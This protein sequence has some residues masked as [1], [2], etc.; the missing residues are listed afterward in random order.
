MFHAPGDSGPPMNPPCA[1]R[2]FL[3][4]L[5][6]DARLLIGGVAA[7]WITTAIGGVLL[8][9][10]A[11]PVSP[12]WQGPRVE[13]AP[14]QR[15]A[16]LL[17]ASGSWTSDE[18]AAD[19]LWE[20][21]L[22][23][24]T[25]LHAPERSLVLIERLLRVHPRSTHTVD[26]MAWRATL[27]A[28][29]HAPEAGSAYEAVARQAPDHADAGRWWLAAADHYAAHQQ[30]LPAIAAYQTATAHPPQ[31][32][33]AWLALGRIQLD[34]DPA[35]AHAAFGEAR[36]AA[37]RHST[38]RLARLG[39]ITALERLE[40][41]DAALAEVDDAIASDGSDPSLERRRDRLLNGG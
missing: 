33:R 31:A 4:A 19:A 36:S 5:F 21:A 13:R 16:E 11:F 12:P 35:A 10:A 29:T 15:V 32:A 24:A 17:H 25:D 34:S 40:G 41:P 18:Q 6:P 1:K 8:S 28:Q 20:A 26:A 9:R 14:E 22:L 39:A 27:L 30:T 23:S 37:R 2:A 7:L 3:R 38:A